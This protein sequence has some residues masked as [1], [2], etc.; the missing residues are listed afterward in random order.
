MLFLS[1]CGLYNLDNFVLP[2]DAEFLALVQE[3]DTP[4]KISDYMVENF[5]YEPHTFYILTPYELFIIKKGDCDEFSNFARFVANYHNFET[6]QIKIFYEGTFKKHVIAIF[7][8]NSYLSVIDFSYYFVG[9]HTFREIVNFNEK[10][11]IPH[12]EWSKYIVYG[13]DMN[14]VEKATK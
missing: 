3:L 7:V 13:Y 4:Q 5:T 11:M 6:Y 10:Y 1:G 2:D 8:E 9:F 14:I 12:R